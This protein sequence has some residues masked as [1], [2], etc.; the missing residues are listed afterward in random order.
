MV[1]AVLTVGFG[2]FETFWGVG[3]GTCV[4]VKRLFAPSTKPSVS[5]WVLAICAC[6]GGQMFGFCQLEFRGLGL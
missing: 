2:F 6:F 1:S 5:L 4:F 3:F